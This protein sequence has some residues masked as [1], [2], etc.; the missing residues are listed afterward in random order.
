MNIRTFYIIHIQY[1][2]V[3]GL[4][5]STQFLNG[6]CTDVNGGLLTA[7]D[8]NLCI[9][10]ET[11]LNLIGSFG[12]VS[13]Q[14][15]NV[16]E[17]SWQPHADVGTTI[18]VSVTT[19]SD[20]EYRAYVVIDTC[21]DTSN[22][23]TLH[24]NDFA[25]EPTAWPG[26]EYCGL[27]LS[28]IYADLP[29][30]AG[31]WSKI[32]GPGNVSFFPSP[33]INSPDSALV[34]T[35]GIYILGWNI[36]DGVCVKQDSVTFISYQQNTANAGVD[37]AQCNLSPSDTVFLH[38][39]PSLPGTNGIWSGSGLTILEPDNP[40][41]GVIGNPSSSTYK[42]FWTE[43]NG[44]CTDKDTMELNIV[45]QPVANA[46]LDNSNCSLNDTL[47][48]TTSSYTG[49]W[50]LVSGPYGVNFDNSNSASAI[51]TTDDY[52]ENFVLEWKL[53]NSFCSDSDTVVINFYEQPVSIIL[54][55]KDICGNNTSL[56]A[57]TSTNSDVIVRT[58]SF[59]SGPHIPA[60]FSQVNDSVTSVDINS[61][62]YGDY[63][64][65]WKEINGTCADSTDINMAF[66]EQPTANAGTDIDSC[67][68]T[69]QLNA[70]TSIPGTTHKWYVENNPTDIT[71]S[72]TTDSNA[73]ITVNEYDSYEL[74]WTELNGICFSSDTVAVTFKEIP[75]ANAGADD[76]TCG[77]N[78][79][80][81][82]SKS[83][84]ASTVNWSILSGKDTISVAT[85]LNSQVR[86]DS[87]GTYQFLLSENNQGCLSSDLVNI[88]FNYQP[89]TLL[90]EADDACGYEQLI[91][92]VPQPNTT[93][94]IGLLNGPG[95]AN[96]SGSD[97]SGIY[98]I[99]VSDTGEYTFSW[100]AKTTHC[101]SDTGI[102]LHF[103]EPPVAYAEND[104][105]ICGKTGVLKSTLNVGNGTWM[106]LQGP[107][108]ADISNTNST[109]TSVNISD[110][111]SYTFKWQVVN[112][113]C[114]DD[115]EVTVEFLESPIADAGTD[116]NICGTSIILSALPE[117][118]YWNIYSGPSGGQFLPD[119]LTADAEFKIE[120][121]GKYQLLWTATN[122]I[123]KDT[124]SIYL[125]FVNDPVANA[126]PDQE[127]DNIFE[128]SMQA[129][130]PQNQEHGSWS[131]TPSEGTG[132]IVNLSSPTS[133]VNNL[134]LG[135]N[136]FVWKVENE[137]CSSEDTVSIFVYDIFIPEIIT[138]NADGENDFF[139][140]TGIDN[141]SP[142][143]LTVLNR[144][145]VEVYYSENYQ[146]D[147]DG[148][149]KNGNYLT[150]DT[151]FYVL[152]VANNRIFK[153]FVIL[154]K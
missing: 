62:A 89:Q 104:S 13:W 84:P 116:E 31:F 141:I 30:H 148:T 12:T 60:D 146:N 81:H 76:D 59:V 1:F 153:G 134:S 63:T 25:E 113:I 4:V 111:G 145:G 95:S 85:E 27:K 3:L 117:S 72:D 137:F 48:A 101:N 144:W 47:S 98:N 125:N 132:N 80:L 86:V 100:E 139:Y 41:T 126:G 149:N 49:Y 150:N 96:I 147:W 11:T 16:G 33:N 36:T 53:I 138:P 88:T 83:I 142:V 19:S 39:I 94:N 120:E 9:N 40:N 51:V 46:G 124:N 6:Q 7:T 136:S 87:A 58:W 79:L 151:Y 118:G 103:F 91:K 110:Y 129:T 43:N 68:E 127:L 29:I 75:N 114:I 73:V 45:R 34:D 112:G 14:W 2:L 50:S 69:V 55:N 131:S 143:E 109:E 133:L 92:V 17:T 15:R 52:G 8:T 122:E 67:G 64:F 102:S 56:E 61:D 119:S 26:A 35:A 82:A 90:E 65:R 115:D 24:I 22:I 10:Q 78:Y 66:F 128:T 57:Y 152:N 5:V 21:V 37:I 140:I 123:C 18:T 97:I 130:P 23:V 71:F 70:R 44:L 135:K 20:R 77:M 154:K 108:N 32:S 105:Q 121:Y 38:A 74:I 99:S 28:S 107:G 93:N 42:L 106:L 54:E